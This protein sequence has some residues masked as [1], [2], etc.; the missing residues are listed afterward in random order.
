MIEAL[1]ATTLTVSLLVVIAVL[2]A[3]VAL[4]ELALVTKMLVAK[5]L[6]E[7][8]LF[9][10][11]ALTRVVTLVAMAFSSVILTTVEWSSKLDEGGNMCV[12]CNTV[13]HCFAFQK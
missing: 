2:V 5:G 1:I 3:T 4:V 6:A 10:F 11:E 12:H 7:T 8:A 9:V 13:W